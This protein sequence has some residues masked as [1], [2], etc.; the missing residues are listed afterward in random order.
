MASNLEIKVKPFDGSNLYLK[1]TSVTTYM[2]GGTLGAT[3]CMCR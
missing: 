2:L 3:L 1:P